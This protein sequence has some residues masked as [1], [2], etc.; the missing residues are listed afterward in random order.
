MMQFSWHHTGLIHNPEL[1]NKIWII[2][3]IIISKIAILFC[4]IILLVY[5][6]S[7]CSNMATCDQLNTDLDLGSAG[8]ASKPVISF[9]K[10]KF[11]GPVSSLDPD[12]DSNYADFEDYAIDLYTPVGAPNTV[13][14]SISFPILQACDYIDFDADSIT[15]GFTKLQTVSFPELLHADGIELDCGESDSGDGPYCPAL[16]SISF[17]KLVGVGDSDL[18]IRN[19]W[20]TSAVI[21]FPELVSW[22]PTSWEFHV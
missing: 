5:C 6:L 2:K 13:T 19:F 7:D 14:T 9:P 4:L 10:L 1:M 17:P 11:C 21:S 15:P 12:V 22:L 18:E 8:C 16:T 3:I 20:R